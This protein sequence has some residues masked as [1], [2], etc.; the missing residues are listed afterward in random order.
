M[1]KEKIDRFYRKQEKNRRRD[2]FYASEVTDCKRKI[3]LKMKGADKEDLDPQTRRKFERGDMIHQRLVSALYSAGVVT[4]SEVRM[5]DQSMFHGRA[6]A[7]VSINNENYIVEIK[8]ASPYSFKNLSEPKESWKKQLQIYLNHFGIDK[9]II[10]VECKGTQKLKEFSIEKDE[11]V[12]E[13]LQEEFEK[14]LDMIKKDVIPKK[15]DKGDWKFD[16]CR[17]CLYKEACEES[18]NNLTGFTGE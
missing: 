12:L 11:G 4:A 16:K 8:S 9:G 17:Y 18:S 2:Y 10:L 6:D 7:I 14:L 3:Y 15:P 5:P 13:E 1:L